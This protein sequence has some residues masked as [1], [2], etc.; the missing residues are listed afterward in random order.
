MAAR[1]HV[2]ACLIGF[3]LAVTTQFALVLGAAAGILVRTFPINNF[4]VMLAGGLCFFAAQ[5]TRDRMTGEWP[6]IQAGMKGIVA[7]DKG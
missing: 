3:A 1:R 6:D 4:G 5:A 7:P 2:L